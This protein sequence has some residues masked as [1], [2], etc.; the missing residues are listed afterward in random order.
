MHQNQDFRGIIVRAR[1]R[2]ILPKNFI[3]LI[4]FVNI[5]KVRKYYEVLEGSEKGVKG[6]FLLAPKSKR[7]II[8]NKKVLKLFKLSFFFLF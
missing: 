7:W 8:L 5:N 1:V 4:G 2:P 6:D 3:D